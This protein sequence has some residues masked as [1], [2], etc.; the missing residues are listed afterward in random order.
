MNS[1]FDMNN[2]LDFFTINLLLLMQYTS[3]LL[4]YIY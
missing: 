3:A 2:T 4:M 1:L